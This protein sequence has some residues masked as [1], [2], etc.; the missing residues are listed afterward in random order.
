MK[1]HESG[2]ESLTG[3]SSNTGLCK[4][5]PS[6]KCLHYTYRRKRDHDVDSVKDATSKTVGT[7]ASVEICP[8]LEALARRRKLVQK[9][10]VLGYLSQHKVGNFSTSSYTKIIFY[11]FPMQEWQW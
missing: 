2:S 8:N 7:V 10:N 4:S 1:Q 11:D 9:E 3:T 6:G 5:Q